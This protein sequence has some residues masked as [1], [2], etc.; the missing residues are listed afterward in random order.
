[1]EP[2]AS[3]I[4]QRSSRKSAR[5]PLRLG[6]GV[7]EPRGTQTPR[8]MRRQLTAQTSTTSPLSALSGKSGRSAKS[9]SARVLKREESEWWVVRPNLV[10]RPSHFRSISSARSSSRGPS[11]EDAAAAST[12][13]ALF[14]LCMPPSPN[15]LR[16]RAGARAARARARMSRTAHRAPAHHPRLAR[17]QAG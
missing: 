7:D 10:R 14:P 1:M 11:D 8:G 9:R 12:A 4:G 6:S 5:A 15:G 2:S 13:A 3:S 17:A 16:E